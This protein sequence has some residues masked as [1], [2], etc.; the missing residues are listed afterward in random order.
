MKLIPT[1]Q[2]T[3]IIKAART[4]TKL[5]IVAGAGA[6]KSSTL[7]MIATDLQV[8]CLYLAYNKSMADEAKV[9][10]PRNVE[11][12]STHSLAYKYEGVAIAHKLNRP[13]GAYVNVAG[14]PTEIA[15]Y[16]KIKPI[17]VEEDKFISSVFIAAIVKDTVAKFE[18]SDYKNISKQCIPFHIKGDIEK[19]YGKKFVKL[20]SNTVLIVA[21]KLW[22]D[23][24]DVKSKVLCTHDTYLKMFEL[25][26]IVL[27]Q[28]DMVFLD[29]SQ[30]A[31]D[32]TISILSSKFSSDTRIAVVGDPFQQIYQFRGSVNALN[33]LEGDKYIL[34]KSFRFGQELA[35]LASSI[36]GGRFALKGNDKVSTKVGLN[37]IANE[38][39]RTEIFRTNAY[40]IDRGIQ[41]LAESVPVFIDFDTRDFVNKIKSVQ[42]LQA[43]N[44]K[45]VKHIDIL[46]FNTFDEFLSECED[47][48]E[49][50]RYAKIVMNGN[51]DHYMYTLT[52]YKKPDKYD[53]H[54]I[55]AHR[56]KGLEM[57]N[58]I[59]GDDFPSIYDKEGRYVGLNELE[60]NLLYVAC[61][62]AKFK[63][64]YNTTVQE[65]LTLS[66]IKVSDIKVTKF[67]N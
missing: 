47:N 33:K 25:S 9:K 7:T 21:K 31:N 43:G 54:L 24:I 8:P 52:S 10:F 20:V 60:E 18:H 15:R 45:G 35:D 19:R 23:R 32:C 34:S 14:S 42:E 56:S 17:L 29:E 37:V 58:V 63:L 30:D 64:Q 26:S 59:L 13:Q 57:G 62:R 4:A 65:I 67:E 6:A 16:Y 61:T 5:K 27:S 39:V 36:L 55:T 28:Y 46:P 11:C 22:E 2:Q 50:N 12:R 48:Y 38:E 53:V 1:E 40:L 49:L 66:N 3:T 51:A 41:L 44:I